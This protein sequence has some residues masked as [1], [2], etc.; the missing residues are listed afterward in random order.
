MQFDG[1]AQIRYVPVSRGTATHALSTNELVRFVNP[2]ASCF[3]TGGSSEPSA[4]ENRASKVGRHVPFSNRSQTTTPPEP[5]I[6]LS[7]EA[8]R[9]SAS[10]SM[11]DCPSAGSAKAG[12]TAFT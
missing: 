7:P 8:A 10:P 4:V 6:T 5:N 9:W 11:N 1:M 2:P 12:A 3:K